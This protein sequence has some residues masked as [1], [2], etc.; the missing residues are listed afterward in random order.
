MQVRNSI[1][2]F[3]ALFC[4]LSIA[5]TSSVL[6]SS[7]L[8][9][10]DI[11]VFSPYEIQA[12]VVPG[13]SPNS[14]ISPHSARGNIVCV[15]RIYS[16]NDGEDSSAS[17]SSN[18]G[19]SFLTFLNVFSSNIVVGRA[20]VEPNKMISVGKF[21]N[22][23]DYANG[24][25]GLFYNV[26]AQRKATLNWYQSNRSLY[27]DLTLSELETVSK[28]LISAQSGYSLVGNNC[29]T[30]AARAW[31]SILS[32]SDKNY[33]NVYGTPNAVYQ[34]ITQKGYYLV[35]NGLIQAD[36]DRC[37]YNGSTRITCKD[38]YIP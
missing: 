19:H 22:F 38:K 5:I 28:Y 8:S 26:E 4:I 16:D 1:K 18:F 2:R 20:T 29:A 27:R 23:G 15:M 25:K 37:Y 36:Y 14:A 31:N 3:I 6:T 17:S 30:T 7:A 34:E 13:V 24:F 32:T 10:P 12:G 35:G 21:G 11:N 9:T 33:F